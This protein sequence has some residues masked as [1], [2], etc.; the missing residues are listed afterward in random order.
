M[1]D[2]ANSGD[3]AQTGDI[4]AADGKVG[5]VVG[6]NQGSPVI[7]PFREKPDYLPTKAFV[8]SGE[9]KIVEKHFERGDDG[10]QFGP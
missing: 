3:G 9:M 2:E 10:R 5:R 7:L 8:A 4:V 1:T 6:F